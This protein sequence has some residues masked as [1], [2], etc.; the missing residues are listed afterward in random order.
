MRCDS[1]EFH[2]KCIQTCCG[3]HSFIHTTW[4]CLVTWPALKTCSAFVF[5]PSTRCA[6]PLSQKGTL[7]LRGVLSKT[8]TK[9]QNASLWLDLHTHR[10]RQSDS[11]TDTRTP[12]V[13]G[14]VFT[15]YVQLKSP[16]LS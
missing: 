14:F 16:K 7:I 6:Y 1:H 2:S 3:I 10:Q 5:S 8:K 11:Q 12:I 13:I 9:V 15:A 4:T